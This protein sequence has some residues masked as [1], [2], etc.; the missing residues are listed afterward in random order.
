MISKIIYSVIIS[1]ALCACSIFGSSSDA[2]AKSKANPALLARPLGLSVLELEKNNALS[3]KIKFQCEGSYKIKMFQYKLKVTEGD[4]EIMAQGT[5]RT[6][7]EPN[8]N[9]I[10]LNYPK[11]RKIQFKGLEISSHTWVRSFSELQLTSPVVLT[12]QE[13]KDLAPY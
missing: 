3:V 8:V 10:N 6:W 7:L 4:K 11:N 13:C 9:I 5:Q 1:F 2:A 12:L